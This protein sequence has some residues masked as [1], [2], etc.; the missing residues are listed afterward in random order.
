MHGLYMLISRNKNLQNAAIRTL[1]RS[2]LYE[3]KE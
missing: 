3:I 1:D 2:T